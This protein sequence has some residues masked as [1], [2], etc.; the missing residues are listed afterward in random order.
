MYCLAAGVPLTEEH[1]I[2]RALGGRRTLREA[3][4]EPCRRITGQREQVTLDREF[5]VPRTLLALKRLKARGKSPGRLPAVVLAGDDTARTLTA[6]HFPRGFSL[7]VFEPAGRLAG[8]D[9]GIAAPRIGH[10][11]CTLGR[12]NGAW[13]RPEAPADPGA[14]AWSIAKWAYALAVAEHGLDGDGLQA[15]RDLMLGQRGDVFN[16]L[17]SPASR[18]PVTTEALHAASRQETGGI[19]TLRLALFARA[20]MASYELVLADTPRGTGAMGVGTP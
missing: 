12:D 3:V 1:L 13:A 11:R 15:L 7:P 9:R 17:G 10:V 5:L 19:A 2:P 18:E 14:Y 8:I 4:C 16:V 20:G 6:A